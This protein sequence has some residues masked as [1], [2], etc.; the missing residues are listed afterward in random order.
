MK[1][2][3]QF[4]THT[5]HKKEGAKHFSVNKIYAMKKKNTHSDFDDLTVKTVKHNYDITGVCGR[6]CPIVPEKVNE[7]GK[8]KSFFSLRGTLTVS[9]GWV[10][11]HF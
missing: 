2:P 5:Y 8:K 6:I 11:P 10:K 1:N 4:V 3:A 9:L 7:N